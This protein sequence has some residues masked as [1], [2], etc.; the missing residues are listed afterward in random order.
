A[1]MNS[2]DGFHPVGRVG[3]PDDIAQTVTFLLSESTRWVTGAVWDID[4]GVM[5]GRNV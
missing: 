1:V 5:A 4:G 3:T 2:F